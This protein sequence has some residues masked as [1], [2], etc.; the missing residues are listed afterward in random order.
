MVEILLKI[1]TKVLETDG[2]MDKVFELLPTGGNTGTL[3]GR[4][5]DYSQFIYAKTGTL[6]N[7]H[8]LSGYIVTKSG[9]LLVFSY[10]NNHYRYKTSTIQKQTDTI[11]KD[12][13]LYY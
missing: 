8:N 10:M 12:F 3:D 2:N 5:K 13:Y 6:S 9:K 1:R 4:F 7:N 11:L